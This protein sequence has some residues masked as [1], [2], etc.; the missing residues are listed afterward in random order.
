MY[1]A[2][3]GALAEHRRETEE[4]APRLSAG[5][6]AI[7]PFDAETEDGE[8]VRVVGVVANPALDMLNFVVLKTLD[9]GEIIPTDEGSVWAIGSPS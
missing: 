7:A 9:G 4:D 8:R 2:V 3:L 6:M 5:M 1:N